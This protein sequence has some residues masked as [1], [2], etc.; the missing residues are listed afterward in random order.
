MFFVLVFRRKRSYAEYTRWHATQD[1]TTD[2]F[3]VKI[4][5]ED[6]TTPYTQKIVAVNIQP[7]IP[8]DEKIIIGGAN[9]APPT[10]SLATKDALKDYTRFAVP[11]ATPTNR[12]EGELFVA[13]IPKQ[14][15]TFPAISPPLQ[16]KGL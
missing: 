10:P 2:E 3:L 1:L 16:P 15:V 4:L 5:D 6:L 8:K 12:K 7:V 11:P 13:T 14:E 9:V